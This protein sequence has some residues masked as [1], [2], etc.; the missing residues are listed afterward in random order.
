MAEINEIIPYLFLGSRK[1]ATNLELLEM[2]HVKRVLSVGVALELPQ[3]FPNAMKYARA[4]I[5]DFPDERLL[6]VLD[7]AIEFI[8]ESISKKESVLVHCQLGVSRSASCVVGY[9]ISHEK[10]TLDDALQLVKEK[11]PVANPNFGFKE[12]LKFY[13]ENDRMI[14]SEEK[15]NAVMISI[16]LRSKKRPFGAD[17][18]KRKEI[19]AKLGDSKDT[20]LCVIC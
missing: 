15:Y 2:C 12:Q 13:I 5:E 11:R 4:E 17:D 1:A 18:A 9:L 14:P 6:D 10:M 20:P 8:R 16:R 7:E 3:R 19:L